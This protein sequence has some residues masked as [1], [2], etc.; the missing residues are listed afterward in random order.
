MFAQSLITFMALSSLVPSALAVPK[1]AW[2]RRQEDAQSSR[3]K[4]PFLDALISGAHAVRQGYRAY[5]Y[6][7]HG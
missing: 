1:A 3:S 4:F 5:W 2:V 6:L 7:L